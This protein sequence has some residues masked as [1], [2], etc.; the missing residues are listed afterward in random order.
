MS[1][2]AIYINDVEESLT[3]G[4]GG[5]FVFRPEFVVSPNK[6]Y[7]TTCSKSARF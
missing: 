5:V 3:K 6:S 1:A 4:P 7:F 2:M